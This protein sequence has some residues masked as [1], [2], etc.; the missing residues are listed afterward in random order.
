[1]TTLKTF[2]FLLIITSFATADEVWNSYSEI[3]SKGVVQLNYTG[4]YG[5]FSHNAFDYKTLKN[6]ALSKKLIAKQIEILANYSPPSN[7]FEKLAF[8]INAYNFYTIVDVLNNM[9][10]KSMKD[11]GWKNRHH[12][13]G[14]KKYSLDD[15]EHK[16]I[17]PM[18][19]PRIHFAVN[20]A[21]VSCPG[22]KKTIFTA[23]GVRL[24]LTQ[25]TKEAF[26][27]PLHIRPDGSDVEVTKLLDWFADDFKISIYKDREGF[28][29]KFAPAKLQKEIDGWIDYNW[30]LNSSDNIKKATQ[31]LGL[32]LKK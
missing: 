15:I 12:I 31:K 26:K 7:R 32:T 17:R 9:P 6:D 8:W 1:M 25:Q 4:P 21:S 11:I 29:K 10:V 24:E 13:V 22:L 19:D 3:L 14:G 20:C 18:H 2:I 30:E 23:Q 28:V 16:I 5:D 27:N